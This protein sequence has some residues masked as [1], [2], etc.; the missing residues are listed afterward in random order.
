MISNIVQHFSDILDM[1]SD[2]G[3][4]KLSSIFKLCKPLSDEAGVS[5]LK[6]W[7]SGTYG[8]LAMVDYPY[9]ANFLEP[10]PAWPIKVCSP[11]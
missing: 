10:L 11:R 5:A 1:F 7:L 6:E 3:R 2:V 4:Q 8:N 9:E